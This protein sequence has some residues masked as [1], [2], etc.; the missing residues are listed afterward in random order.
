MYLQHLLKCNKSA[1]AYFLY[2]VIK[3]RM[4][5]VDDITAHILEL[6]KGP[7]KYYAK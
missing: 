5:S 3:V 6:D 4:L 7:G 2:R 1:N